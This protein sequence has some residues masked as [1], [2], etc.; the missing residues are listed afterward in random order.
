[1]IFLSARSYM[2]HTYT[3]ML[4]AKHSYPFLNTCRN[5]TAFIYLGIQY[6]NT[7]MWTKQTDHPQKIIDFLYQKSDSVVKKG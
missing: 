3:G 1:M 4:A 6:P 5:I 7:S 2:T